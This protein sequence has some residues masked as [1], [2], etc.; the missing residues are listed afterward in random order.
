M[1]FQVAVAAQKQQMVISVGP[2][3]NHNFLP[4]TDFGADYPIFTV[5][6]DAQYSVV[7]SN[8]TTYLCSD[9]QTIKPEPCDAE[10]QPA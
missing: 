6:D 9:H 8:P 4:G 5:E 2:T 7:I 1:T 10:A 3:P